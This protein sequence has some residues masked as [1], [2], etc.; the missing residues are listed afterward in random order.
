[1]PTPSA[2]ATT[3]HLQAEQTVVRAVSVTA[4]T[5]A[6]QVIA[7]T[8]SLN[9][10]APTC[11]QRNHSTMTP[12]AGRSNGRPNRRA[13]GPTLTVTECGEVTP[14][15]PGRLARSFKSAAA[16]AQADGLSW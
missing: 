5:T 2:R 6:G 11:R 13:A 4:A 14:G 8:P 7:R 15:Y 12:A 9:G 3:C 16:T 10:A 1:M